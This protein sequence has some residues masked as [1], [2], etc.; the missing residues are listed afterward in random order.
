MPL[1]PKV[2]AALDQ[3]AGLMPP[4]HTFSAQALRDLIRSSPQAVTTTAEVARVEDRVLPGPAG[5][6]PV[7]VYTPE[8]QGTFPVVVYFHGG[9]WTIGT[10]DSHDPICRE[11]CAGASAVVVSVDYR[12]APEH[13]FPAAPDD[14]VAAT[15]WVADHAA[16]LGGTQSASRW[17]GTAREGTSR[18]WWRCGRGMREARRCGASS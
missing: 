3:Q 7:R 12:L 9:G 2:K 15:R 10:L 16:A 5:E 6:L 17:R 14:S 11:L 13:P 1:D 4:L 8:G 18:P